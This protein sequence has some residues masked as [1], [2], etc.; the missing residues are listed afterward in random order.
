MVSLLEISKLVFREGC[1][2]VRRADFDGCLTLL[3]VFA[4]LPALIT[5]LVG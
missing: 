3:V 4:H 1:R 5:T 2:K